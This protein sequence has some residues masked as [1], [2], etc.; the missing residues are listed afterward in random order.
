MI[1]P[2]DGVVW[3]CCNKTDKI[4]EN[5]LKYVFD[6]SGLHKLFQTFPKSNCQKHKFLKIKE[7]SLCN[8]SVID[9]LTEPN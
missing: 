7:N 2:R 6:D 9:G 3:S 1:P 5:I 4:I 8:S